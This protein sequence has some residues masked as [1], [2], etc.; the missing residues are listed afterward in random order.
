MKQIIHILFLV[1]LTACAA[2]KDYS[3]PPVE[4]V[5]TFKE[6]AN[7]K[8]AEPRDDKIQAKWWEVF[9]DKELNQLAEQIATSN[10]S[11]KAAEAAYRQ[12][13]ALT[14]KAKSAYFPNISADA[15]QNRNAIG[16]KANDKYTTSLDAA[17]ELDLWGK[18]RREVEQNQALSK[19]SLADL[20]GVKLSM[21]NELVVDY[22]SLRMADEQKRLL[23]ATIANY[24]KSLQM[25]KNLYNSG[26]NSQED[27]LQA[28]AQLEST[29]T[30]ILDVEISRA[31]F[32]H[33]IAVLVG[34]TP[35][36]FNIAANDS[37]PKLPPTP[38]AIAAEL[39]ERRPD[40]ASAERRVIAAN[41]AIGAAKAAYFPSLKISAS[42]GYQSSSFVDWINLPNRVWSI[43]P[44][45]AL[46]V[47]DGGLRKAQSK[48]A[49]AAYD[50]KV[51]D[52]RQTILA[53]FADVEDNLVTLRLLEQAADSQKKASDSSS[54]A[55]TITANQYKAGIVSYFNVITTQNSEINNKTALL[56]INK[57]RLIATANLIKAL[58]GG[59]TE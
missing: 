25:T 51:A 45:I 50:Q 59:W 11:V 36:D 24:E 39:L 26:V 31:K 29:K 42:G 15:A 32:E 48:A 35:A 17:W 33:A 22:I 23:A 57:Q 46:N 8:K 43:G 19:A 2:G 37:I 27:V 10:Q 6:A 28:T 1:I 3:R 58:G 55:A 4:K 20:A 21:Q 9:E 56:N 40:I 44:D 52:Y 38:P 12:A 41:A 14:A 49:I 34:K 53:S 7:W 5:A 30:Q 16:S 47:F 54:Q 18:I 13:K